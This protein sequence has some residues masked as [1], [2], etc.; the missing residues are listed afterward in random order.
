MKNKYKEKYREQWKKYF[1]YRYGTDPYCEI[2]GQLL[3]W[4]TGSG[5]IVNFD[6]RI[7]NV[8]IVGETPSHWIHTRS[9]NAKNIAIWEQCHFGIL[10]RKCNLSLPDPIKREDWLLSALVYNKRI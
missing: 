10:C 5:N 4:E 7:T 9:C 1:Q 3:S 8:P 2:C 6:H